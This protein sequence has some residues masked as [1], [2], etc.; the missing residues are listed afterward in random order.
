LLLPC[1][2]LHAC[3]LMF[4][5]RD[6]EWRFEAKPDARFSDFLGG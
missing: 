5:W 2:A 4:Q 3:E 1:H 6:R